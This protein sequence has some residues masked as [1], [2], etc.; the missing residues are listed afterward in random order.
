M[1]KEATSLSETDYVNSVIYFTAPWCGPCRMLGPLMDSFSEDFTSLNFI[2]VNI[3]NAPEVAQEH[4]IQSIPT[5]Q[6]FINGDRK[7]SFVGLQ[8]KSTYERAFREYSE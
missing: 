1:F 2:K 5:V 4:G 3:D 8:P 7:A 6:L